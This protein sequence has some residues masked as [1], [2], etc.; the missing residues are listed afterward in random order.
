MKKSIFLTLLLAAFFV[1][2]ANPVDVN[3]AKSIGAKFL[4]ASTN[5]KSISDLK[6]AATYQIDRG[7]A[8]FYVFNADNAFVI[9]SDDDCATPI[10]AYSDEGQFDADD[11]PPAM[12]EYLYGFVERIEY[13]VLNNISDEKTTAKWEL[14]KATGRMSESKNTP[15]VG[16]L[17]SSAWGQGSNT[18]R[19][20]I[21]KHIQTTARPRSC[22]AMTI[23]RLPLWN[24][25]FGTIFIL[26][27]SILQK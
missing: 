9:V 6:L 17:L 24:T 5:L 4:K 23:C 25:T 16:P 7:D 22:F 26:N 3:T 2:S 21:S 8:A 11:V 27:I 13:G 12:Q 1:A 15:V 20:N 19:Y 10:L 14:V 18:C